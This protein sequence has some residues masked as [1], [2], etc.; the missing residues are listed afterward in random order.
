M[1]TFL[2]LWVVAGLIGFFLRLFNKGTYPAKKPLWI[3][4]IFTHIIFGL[5]GLLYGYICFSSRDKLSKD[6]LR[7]E[8]DFS[9]MEGGVKDKYSQH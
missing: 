6:E 4:I 1:I 9:K 5:V 3:L 7:D 8:Y 2:I